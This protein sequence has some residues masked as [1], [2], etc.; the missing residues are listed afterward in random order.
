MLEHDGLEATGEL[1]RRPLA[2]EEAVA[3]LVVV[4]DDPFW[5]R[6]ITEEL[7]EVGYSSTIDDRAAVAFDP[8][9]LTGVDLCIVDLDTVAASGLAACAAIR[10]RSSVPIIATGRRADEVTV[11]AAFA[12]GI[13][14]YVDTEVTPRQ[15]VARVR[16]VLRRFPP[17]RSAPVLTLVA[18]PVVL[19]EGTCSASV[20]GVSVALSREEFAVLR[21]L[22][23]RTG[24]VVGRAELQAACS[25]NVGRDRSVESVIRC[26][27]HKLE[28]VD[29][30][31]RI[32]T[33]RSIGF[34]FVVDLGPTIAAA[35]V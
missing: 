25:A 16:A 12:A 30:C 17:R 7:H 1:S 34:R 18:G 5:S 24:R 13:D 26:L 21:L 8:A 11:L 20:A 14:Q 32:L 6:Q 31:R 29:S 15:F 28:A 4:S 19:D 10:A 22:V 9:G 23:A 35:E 3:C 27:R 33:V 2:S